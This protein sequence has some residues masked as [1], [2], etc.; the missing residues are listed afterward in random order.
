MGTARYPD[1]RLKVAGATYALPSPYFRFG[2]WVV[3][4]RERGS[5]LSWTYLDG[6]MGPRDGT[7]PFAGEAIT[8]EYDTGGGWVLAFSG[9]CFGCGNQW[10]PQG[11]ARQYQAVGLRALGDRVPVTN[12]TTGGDTHVFNGDPDDWLTYQA[13]L[14]GRTVGQILTNVLTDPT[15]APALSGQGVGAYTSLTPPTLPSSTTTDLAAM[16]IIPPYPVIIN[17]EKAIGSIEAALRTLAPNH[18]LHVEPGGAVRFLDQRLFGSNTSGYPN[19][20]TLECT[21][22]TN[23]DLVDVAAVQLQ[24]DVANSFPR[25]LV[26]GADYAEMKL[27]TQDDGSVTENFAHSGLTLAQAKATWKLSDFESPDGSTGQAKATCALSGGGI[28]TTFTIQSPGFGYAA[29]PTISFTGGGGSG[30]AATATISGGQVTAI[31]RTA[32]GSGYTSAPTMVFTTPDGGSSD[33]GTCTCPTTTTVTA[34]SADN[35]KTWASNYWDQSTGRHGQVFLQY[36]SGAGVTSR[37]TRK[38]V[39]NTALAAGGTSTLTLDRA[40]PGTS[41]NEYTIRGFAGAGTNVWRKYQLADSTVRLKIRPVA[42][43]PAPLLNAAGNA[44]TMTST[45]T[46]EVLYSASGGPPEFS[47]PA[48]ISIDFETGDIYFERPTVEYFGT[49]ANLLVGGP[50]TDGIPTNIRLFLPIATGALTA[51]YPA[52]VS[53]SPTYAGTSNTVDGITDTLTV[54][55]PQWK[56]PSQ[57]SQVLAY[58]QE[59][60]DSV[61]D[62]AIEGVV[63][64]ARFDARFLTPG[65]GVRLTGEGYA[66]PYAGITLPVVECVVRFD[67][68]PS[69]YRTELKVSTRRAAYTAGQFLR[70]PVKPMPAIPLGVALGPVAPYVESPGP[71]VDSPDMGYPTL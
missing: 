71:R 4:S 36:T 53:G 13:S 64:L 52:D 61:K 15:M 51:V 44:G 63:P 29:A 33:A 30:A 49:R 67:A 69:K 18:F 14:A 58:A 23:P 45:P 27:F 50:S 62:T 34:T 65:Q 31:T 21:D 46:A 40:L 25:V 38:I 68:G 43:F 47:V 5:S 41:F 12:T 10:T 3:Y 9:K 57:S 66:L 39:S 22:T 26:R 37:V 11:W 70:P 1:W 20:I 54:T 60:H 19:Y 24:D 32:A 59:L 7:D 2:E 48:P 56:D 28:G 42:T 8:L 6:K 55:V 17:G 35:K 16:T